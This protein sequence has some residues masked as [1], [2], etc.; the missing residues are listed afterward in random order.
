MYVLEVSQALLITANTCWKGGGNRQGIGFINIRK[1]GSRDT[2]IESC[3][4]SGNGFSCLDSALEPNAASV[5]INHIINVES[6]VKNRGLAITGNTL[7]F[8]KD[9]NYAVNI[10]A[11]EQYTTVTGNVIRNA[12]AN[13][14]GDNGVSPGVVKGFNVGNN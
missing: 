4:I 12:Q 5:R 9:G 11:G 2:V 6:G 13:R 7:C 3:T 1:D 14:C 8:A 10:E